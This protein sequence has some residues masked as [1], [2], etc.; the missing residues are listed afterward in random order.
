MVGKKLTITIE[1]KENSSLLDFWKSVVNIVKVFK[2]MG[3]DIDI[4]LDKKEERVFQVDLIFNINHCARYIKNIMGLDIT[5]EQII[6]ILELETEYM[7]ENG[8]T[9]QEG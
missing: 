3:I 6:R 4:V 7:I 2:R 1:Q 8:Y 9:E 5:E